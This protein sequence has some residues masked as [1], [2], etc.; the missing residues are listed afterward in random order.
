[1]QARLFSTETK[2]NYSQMDYYDIL[3]I[4]SSAS[5]LDI[6]KSYLRLAKKY[7]PDVYKEKINADHFKK[8][9]EAFATLKN[10]VKRNDYDK[11]KKVKSQKNEDT[12]QPQAKETKVRETIDPEFEAAFR[13]LNINRQFAE[14]MARPM[15][16]A[17]EELSES[18]MQPVQRLKMSKRDIARGQ[19]IQKF[20]HKQKIKQS[21]K[22]AL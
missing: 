20:R 21:L 15:R 22:L 6:K 8:V 17:P 14:F 11:R 2:F 16:S 4:D 1:M 3:E 18:L 10:P 9:N 13:K 12:A 5:D 7:H 19:F